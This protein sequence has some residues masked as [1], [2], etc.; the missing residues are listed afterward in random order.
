MSDDDDDDDDDVFIG[1]L[2]DKDDNEIL[3]RFTGPSHAEISRQLR[4]AENEYSAE[5]DCKIFLNKEPDTHEKDGK[6][7]L[8]KEPHIQTSHEWWEERVKK[9][10]RERREEVYKEM[11]PFMR[12]L[13]GRNLKMGD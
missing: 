3:E 8:G 10:A 7:Y 9:E 4:E 11:S 1:L 6:E 2:I 5:C 12:Y 13:F